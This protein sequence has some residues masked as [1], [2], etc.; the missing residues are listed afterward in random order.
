MGTETRLACVLFHA[1]VLSMKRRRRAGATDTFS[2]SIDSETKK[3]LKARADR[4]YG[5]NVSALITEMARE[6]SRLEA[7]A[8]LLAR[9]GGSVLDDEA[10]ARIDAELEAGWRQAREGRPR[11]RKRRAA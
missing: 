3:A 1:T 6:A 8:R 4:L 11:P 10:R 9:W 2:V 7:M 5:G